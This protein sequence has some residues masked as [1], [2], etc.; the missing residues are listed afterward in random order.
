ML[1]KKT[2]NKTK[3]Q[4][5]LKDSILKL[6]KAKITKDPKIKVIKKFFGFSFTF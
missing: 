5:S 6:P 4:K 2:A 1:L 3:S